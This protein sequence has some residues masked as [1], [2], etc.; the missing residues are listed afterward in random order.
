VVEVPQQRRGVTGAQDTAAGWLPAASVSQ[1]ATSE[2]TAAAS[3]TR[4]DEPESKQ[5]R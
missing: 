1:T 2:T 4:P 5:M 3:G